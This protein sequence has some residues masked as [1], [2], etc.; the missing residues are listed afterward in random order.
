[1]NVTG[2]VL[3]ANNE[4]LFGA[5]VYYVD[6]NSLKY[7][8]DLPGTYVG[9]N[10]LPLPGQ[11]ILPYIDGVLAASF[12]G[13]ETQYFNTY[14][15]LDGSDTLFVEFVLPESSNVLPEVVITPENEDLG[16]KSVWP[17]LAIALLGLTVVK[18]R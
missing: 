10:A 1:M 17:W 13:Y 16:K 8:P 3:D 4:P 6:P 5:N 11:F 15:P 12:I 18:K 7:D 14:P 2:I 9:Q